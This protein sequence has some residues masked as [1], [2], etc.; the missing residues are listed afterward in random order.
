MDLLQ[1]WGDPIFAQMLELTALETRI[2][3]AVEEFLA[4]VLFTG[5][6]SSHSLVLICG[7]LLELLVLVLF[8]FRPLQTL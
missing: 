1:Y 2:L 8:R 5:Y 7:Q 6:V 4:H 3:S